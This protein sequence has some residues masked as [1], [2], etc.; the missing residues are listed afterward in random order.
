MLL[1]HSRDSDISGLVPT[2]LSLSRLMVNLA[3]GSFR[4]QFAI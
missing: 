2:T 3:V 1:I 4:L